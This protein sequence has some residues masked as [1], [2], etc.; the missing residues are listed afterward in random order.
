MLS[1]FYLSLASALS[2]LA[3]LHLTSS[4]VVPPQKFPMLPRQ[5]N[6]SKNDVSLPNA[7]KKFYANALCSP[8]KQLIEQLTWNDA[9]L[10]ANA[11]A[12]W[13]PNGSYQAA[14][15][16]YMGNDSRGP[17]GDILEGIRGFHWLS[18]AP[19]ANDVLFSQHCWGSQRPYA[20]YMA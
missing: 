12:S 14:M 11:L 6:S 16:M 4:A 10:Y 1:I 20:V 3:P 15:D 17:I 5:T 8:E 13:R 9:S 19:L 7:T 2:F 18:D